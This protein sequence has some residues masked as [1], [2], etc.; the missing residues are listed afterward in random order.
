[1]REQTTGW[2]A[3]DVVADQLGELMERY[4]SAIMDSKALPLA[5]PHMKAALKLAW[6]A[7]EDELNRPV[8]SGG[9]FV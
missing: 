7:L 4:P 1:M 9:D 5:K 2:L 3:F 8:F 6:M